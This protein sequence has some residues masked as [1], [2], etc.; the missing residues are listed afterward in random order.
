VPGSPV[1]IHAPGQ[2][3]GVNEVEVACFE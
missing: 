1:I 2:R 3:L